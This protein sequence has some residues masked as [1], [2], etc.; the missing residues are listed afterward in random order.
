MLGKSILI[1]G[2]TGLIGTYFIYSLLELN[3]I[4]T[5]KTIIRI[6]IHRGLP[7]HLSNLLT[8]KNVE[9]YKGD[10]QDTNFCASLPESDYIIHAARC[11]KP[12]EVKINPQSAIEA[13]RLNTTTTDAL[14]N[15]L[16]SDNGEMLF[17]STYM[18][19][20]GSSDFPYRETSFGATMPDHKRAYH[21]ESN[22]C[23]ETICHTWK[24]LGKKSKIVRLGFVYGP[25]VR[26]SDKRVVYDFIRK[27]LN[28]KIDLLDAGIL[29]R[30]YL[31]VADA[32]ADMWKVLLY[33]KNTTYNIG[34]TSKAVTV[35]ELAQIIGKLMNVPVIL[36]EIS[37]DL[38]FKQEGE[39]SI[40]KLKNEFGERTYLSL[41][42]GL[43]RT[44][45]WYKA[46]IAI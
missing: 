30:E 12:N 16:A 31:Y 41:E 43:K 20:S 6:V 34:G 10:L 23:G 27:G 13:I 1:T 46:N 32:V 25:G 36:P 24:K 29:E 37:D 8:E 15:N 4:S 26:S 14:M 39:V 5:E 11:G 19:Y 35:R 22:R 2:A 3:K 33:G 44:I 28:G 21:I 17:L 18:V 38:S 9:I 42:E 45:Q 40:D 7:E